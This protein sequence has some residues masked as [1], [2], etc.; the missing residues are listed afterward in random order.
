MELP[1]QITFRNLDASEALEADIRS[2]VEKLEQYSDRIVAC[3]VIVEVHHK[4]HQQG[5]LVHVRV[6]LTVPGDN[7]IVSREPH[8][9]HAHEDPYVAV[10]DAFAAAHRQLKKCVKRQR[11]EVKKH[12]IP[13]HGRIKYLAPMNDHGT[14]ETMDG[15]EI[16]FHRNSL[17][18]ADLD[19]LEIGNEVRFNESRGD[20]GP[21]A[22]TVKLIGKHHIVG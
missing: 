21:Q 5:N 7:I 18:N 13:S 2:K 3:R 16:Y 15:R 1:L 14:I 12:E 8:E 9:Q 11:R 22:S 17:I 19:K 4:H 10:R 6:D 20:N